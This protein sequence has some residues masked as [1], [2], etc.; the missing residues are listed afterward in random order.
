MSTDSNNCSDIN[1]EQVE[2]VVFVKS[3][4]FRFFVYVIGF[5][6]VLYIIN[7]VLL[8]MMLSFVLL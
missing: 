4:F 7:V 3:A 1:T 5:A 2:D 6:F 8:N